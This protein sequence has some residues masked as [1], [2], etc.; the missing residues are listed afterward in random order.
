ML[1]FRRLAFSSFASLRNVALSNLISRAVMFCAAAAITLPAQTFTTL[2]SFDG[3]N[4]ANPQAP[5]IQGTDGNFYG[6]TSAGGANGWPSNYGTA[7]KVTPSGALTTLHNFCSQ[8]NCHDGKQVYAGLVQAN[9]GNFYGVTCGGNGGTAFKVTP[10]GVLTTL[11]A[12][13]DSSY[14][15]MQASDGNF[16]GIS[17]GYNGGTVFKITP[18]G[19]LTTLYN[20]C[21]QPNCADGTSPD[22]LV[23][24]SDG[25]F[26]GTTASGGTGSCYLGCGTFF[27]IT[28]GGTLTTL[29]SFDFSE[30]YF[31]ASL[32]QAVDGNFYVTTEGGVGGN[33]AIF[34]VDASGTL[35]TLYSFCSQPNCTDGSSPRGALFQ[36][37]DGNFYGT[38]VL[39]GANVSCNSGYGCG[40]VFKITPSGTLTTLYSFCSQANC[41]DG[42]IPVAG[43]VQAS[44]GDF[45]G[46]TEVGGIEVNCDDGWNCGSGTVFRL[47]AP[48]AAPPLQFV[49]VVPCRVVDTRN[50]DGQFG[51]P[52][53]Q[54]GAIGRS[55]PI[56]LGSCNIPS[57][58]VVYSL[59]VTVV[60]HGPLGY[61]TIW[62]AGKAQPAVSTMNSPDGRIKANAALVSAGPGGAVS[63]YATDTT[64]V[65]LDINGYF[66]PPASNT[67][68]FYTLTPCRVVDTRGT[69]GD[70]GG[71]YLRAGHVRVFPVVESPCLQGATAYSLNVTVVPHP[72]GQP[73][74]Y[75]TVWAFGEPQPAV[76]TLNNPTATVVANAAIVF[77][78]K[79]Q[80][81][82]VYATDNTDLIID[83]NGYFGTD[84]GGLS[85]YPTAPCRVLDTRNVGSGQPFQGVYN[86]PNGID[87]LTSPCAPPSSAQAYV[88]NATVVPSGPM[89]YLTVWP[90]SSDQPLVSTLNAYDGFITSNMAIVPTNDGSI[91]AYAAGLTH[92]VLDIFGYFAP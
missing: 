38:T 48:H 84:T 6:T 15:L 47:S 63:V 17:G 83:I 5:V 85:L 1:G 3:T 24:A 91:D 12:G 11:H 77:A 31:V 27:K 70:L 62:P 67:Y 66:T 72:A 46:T 55:F 30:G 75:L 35:T 53:I 19:S 59:N 51:G 39:G 74:G 45:Y 21:S 10:E 52:A 60:P 58:A 29:H 68:Q 61:L 50:P 89:P 54:G 4:G 57:S 87:V 16:Y 2:V 32:M 65:I 92:L 80:Y 78:G 34:K 41:T 43:L 79:Y 82:N 56:A 37:T 8:P 28:P 64:D 13:V 44:D 81:I 49:P 20:F 7:F 18:T 33:G 9:D 23:Q 71:P 36:A 86:S 22:G 42:A 14:A 90:H 25:N 26:Y 76:S 69:D 88:F 40:T 73:L